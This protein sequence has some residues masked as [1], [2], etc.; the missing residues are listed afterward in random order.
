MLA[1]VFAGGEKYIQMSVKGTNTALPDDVGEWPYNPI[2]ALCWWLPFKL[3]GGEFIRL[4][5]DEKEVKDRQDFAAQMDE[6]LEKLEAKM[7]VQVQAQV[8]ALAA[9]IARPSSE[10]G[11]INT[12]QPAAEIQAATQE[13]AATAE[14]PAAQKP[15]KTSTK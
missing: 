7:Q 4:G 3:A 10:G 11:S 15:P 1:G 12:A 2:K 13:P 6:K 9:T 5:C 14:K 8:Q